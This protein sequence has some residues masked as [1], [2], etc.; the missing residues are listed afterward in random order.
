MAQLGGSLADGTEV[1]D[2]ASKREARLKAYLD[3]ARAEIGSLEQAGV[4]LAGNAFSAVLFAKGEPNDAEQ[5]DPELLL[6]G[7]DGKALRASLSALGYPPEAWAALLTR[8]RSGE[9]LKADLVRLAVATLDPDTLVA[10]DETAA[11]ALREAYA[12]DLC[13][14]DAFDEAVLA[15]GVVARVRGMRVMNLGGF[16]AALA[17]DHAKQVMWARLKR[18]PPLGEPY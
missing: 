4:V 11:D 1:G 16:E 14:L 18:L 6:S 15:P 10:C 8:G 9:P 13:H 12:D 17:D 2:M 3:K 7:T 5:A